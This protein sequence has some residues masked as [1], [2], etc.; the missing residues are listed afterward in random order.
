MKFT[1]RHIIFIVII[2]ITSLGYSQKDK[3]KEADKMFE[4]YAFID[5]Q[6]NLFGGS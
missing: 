3:L 5:A 4:S 6:K 2:L 1:D